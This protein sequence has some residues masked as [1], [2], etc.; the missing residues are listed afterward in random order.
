MNR[1]GG[2]TLKEECDQL[3]TKPLDQTNQ[4]IMM[5]IKRSNDEIKELKESLENLQSSHNEMM[6]SHE[7]VKQSYVLLEQN[8]AAVQQDT[9]TGNVRGKHLRITLSS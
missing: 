6:K 3:R 8:V 4:E 5:D 1:L 7:E 9:M 2:Q